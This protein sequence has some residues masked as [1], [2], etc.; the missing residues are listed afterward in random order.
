ML[1]V[2]I[3][4]WLTCLL[5]WIEAPST[6]E[7]EL[8][9]L[10]FVVRSAEPPKAGRGIALGLERL[11][12]VPFKA[13]AATVLVALALAVL[14]VLGIQRIKT[15]DS[16]S[17]L[18]RSE[19]P[20]FQQF[21]QVSRDFPSSEYDVMIVASGQSLLDRASVDKLRDVVTDV[22]L[23][24]G[25]RGALSMFS[26]RQPAPQGGMPEPLFSDPLPEGSAYHQLID[27]VKK[28]EIIRGKLLSDDGRLAVVIL[29]LE[30]S[31]VDG[32]RLEAVVNDIRRTAE[33]DLQGT[34]LTAELT[35]VPVM[36]LEIRH[37]LERDRILYN[38]VGFALGCAIAAFFFRRLSL[39]LVAA[40]P[41][42]LAIVF[43]LGAL[44]WLGFRLNMF[45]NVMTPLIMV[46]SFSDSMQLTF[47]ARDQLMAGKDKRTAFRNAILI[48]GPACVLT[49]AAAGLSLLG[50]LAASSDLIRGFGE[51]GF[52]STA[53][54]LVTVLSLVPTFG[55][56]LVRDEARLIARLR[57][58]D[59]GVAT[60]RRFC[61]WIARRMVSRPA[62]FSLLALTVV[63]ALAAFYAGLEPSYRLADQVPDKEQ[64][65]AASGRLDAQISGSNPVEALITFPPGMGLY[66]PQTL[67][68][69]AD[70][71]RV[72]ESQPGVGNVW[73]LD[74]LRRWL[75]EQMG[76][77]GVDALRQYVDELP[78]FLVRR[79]IAKDGNSVVVFGLVPD[80]SLTNLVPIVDELERRL[81]AVRKADPGYGIAVTGLSVIAAQNSAGMIDKLNRALTVE[82]AFIAAFI[83]LAFRSP[84]VGLACLPSG[85][86]PVVAGGSLLR[87]FGYGL[88]FSG[89]VALFVSFGLGLSATIHFL[90]RMTQERRGDEDPAIAVERATV[91]MGPALI[92]TALVLACG[93]AALVFSDLPP[94]RLFG[95]LGALAM[96]AA[97]AADLLILRPVVT[98]LLRLGRRKSPPA[99]V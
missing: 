56:L 63:A 16:L 17:Q 30:R 28:N 60:L 79:F 15:D 39:V 40:A 59:P 2:R 97:L 90:N 81:N 92:L 73:S 33:E 26:A 49:H 87:L 25:T 4:I 62:L 22:Q 58:A 1:A 71:Q 91:L 61:D 66:T 75:V 51:A 45:L 19:D 46:I 14:A 76:L 88:Q 67:A 50:L 96:L 37:A 77:T 8:K 47:A 84:R 5:V 85:V 52:L 18:F 7:R 57:A 98:F 99:P 54:A 3:G 31:A 55:V 43:A 70:V 10:D 32:G 89:V 23:I 13:P 68:T 78:V 44:G 48:V 36:Q 64:A 69:I 74:S 11:A 20:A 24:D 34:G 38:A 86:F 29:S 12:L 9:A 41:P 53:I 65:V 6:K 21:E 72:L 82:F 42:L 27:R 93:L 83:G 94:L 95:W 80:K 35:G